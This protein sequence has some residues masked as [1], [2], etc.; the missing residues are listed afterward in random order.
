MTRKRHFRANL[1]SSYF[2]SIRYILFAHVETYFEK[3]KEKDVNLPGR[4]PGNL[5]LA[6]ARFVS[7]LR[8]MERSYAR[9]AALLRDTSIIIVR[10]N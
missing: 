8:K 7:R 2:W 1:V 3:K 10:A 6:V 4:P 9:E 5:S